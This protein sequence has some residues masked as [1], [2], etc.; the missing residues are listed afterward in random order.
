[1]KSRLLT[2]CVAAAALS[3]APLPAPR[4]VEP[5]TTTETPWARSTSDTGA[6]IDAKRRNWNDREG[7]RS[8]RDNPNGSPAA[9]PTAKEGLG[10]DPSRI[11]DAPK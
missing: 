5:P 7:A 10:G 1:M 2:V 11:S 8:N 3:Q 9:P 6:A 4:K